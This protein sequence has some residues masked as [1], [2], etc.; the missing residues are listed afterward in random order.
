MN[1]LIVGGGGR[2]HAL[3]WK[4]A[5]SP[6]VSQLYCAPGNPGIAAHSVCAPL[7][8]MDVDGLVAFAEEKEIG[9][10]VVG[11]EDPLA[12][13]ITDAFAAKDLQVFGPSRGAAALESS[14]SFAKDLMER[15]EIPTAAY[16]R[17]T[18]P[19]AA[20]D[21][22]RRAGRPLVVK[23]DGLA[24]GKGV[25]VAEDE[26]GAIAAVEAAMERRVFG[27][28][29][30]AV[31]IEERLVGEEAS[32]LALADGE[33][34]LT[35]APSQDHKPV[36]DGGAGPNTGGMGAYSPT[37]AVT[38]EDL[39]FI[40]EHVVQ[41]CVDAMAKEGLPYQGVLYAGLMLTDEGPKVVEFNCRFGDP[42]TQVV[43][44]RLENDLLP[45]LLAACEGTLDSQALVWGG[46]ACVTVVLA[47]GG[48]PG[49]YEKG[50]VI[51]GVEEAE[52][53]AGVHVF[54]AGTRF[55][56]GR[57]LTNGGR[58]LNVT[59]TGAD[60]PDAIAKAYRAVDKVRFEGRHFR[61]DIGHKALER[62][63]K[64]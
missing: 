48:Y 5:K 52:A 27:A 25:T 10:T 2:E 57:L 15:Y 54:H 59:A 58:V 23:A 36:F 64:A 13:G 51:M 35:L 21:Y 47:S 41:R 8:P 1:V 43:L 24:A 19:E 30:A 42:E 38:D 63:G 4:L 20:K 12:A 34:I 17:F 50:K 40:E 37:P 61:R 26:A 49:V 6:G 11:P 7:D 46:G 60:I 33:N 9:L 53:E 16:A 39:E 62:L 22:I 45:L 44:P 18:D 28:A 29:G 56:E 55:E 14:K 31:V 32:V 3:A